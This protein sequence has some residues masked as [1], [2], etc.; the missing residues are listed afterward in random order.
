VVVALAST[1]LTAVVG[2]DAGAGATVLSPRRTSLVRPKQ[3]TATAAKRVTLKWVADLEFRPA[4][5]E[6]AERHV[7]S[8]RVLL[9]STSAQAA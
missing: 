9:L 2:D 7:L 8:T 5:S 4:A 1:C 6:I 3:N